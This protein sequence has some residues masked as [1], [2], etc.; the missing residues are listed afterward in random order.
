MFNVPKQCPNDTHALSLSSLKAVSRTS[1]TSFSMSPR[2]HYLTHAGVGANMHHEISTLKQAAYDT[3]CFFYPALLGHLNP[4]LGLLGHCG[5][6]LQQDLQ[7]QFRFI[8]WLAAR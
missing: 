8:P 5:Q 2:K 7:N 3:N 6:D 4:D 1:A